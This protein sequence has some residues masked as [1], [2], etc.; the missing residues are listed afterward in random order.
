M[1]KF[2]YVSNVLNKYTPV[3]KVKNKVVRGKRGI[4]LELGGVAWK[5][6]ASH[7]HPHHTAEF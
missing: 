6:E 3:G 4:L 2:Q 7:V 1:L 5:I